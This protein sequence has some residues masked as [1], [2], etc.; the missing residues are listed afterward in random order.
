MIGWVNTTSAL[1]LPEGLVYLQQTAA[2]TNRNAVN[3]TFVLL[4][5]KL[6]HLLQA[7][8]NASML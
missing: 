2:K 1:S 5:G 6:K 4:V 8:H 7:K 3:N